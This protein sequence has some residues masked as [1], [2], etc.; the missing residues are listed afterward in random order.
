MLQRILVI[1]DDDLSREVVEIVLSGEGYEVNGASSGEVAME[2]LS[3]SG[4]L[5]DAVLMDMQ[6]PGVSGEELARR[7]RAVCGESMRLIA[8]SGS[9]S[10]EAESEE[11]DGFLLKPFSAEEFRAILERP[12]RGSDGPGGAEEPRESE[13]GGGTDV[14]D[15]QIFASF[16]A[17]MSKESLRDLYG[18]CV[19]DATRQLGAMRSA[20]AAGDD[21]EFRKSAHLIKG[22]LGMLGVR[23]LQGMCSVLEEQG[24]TDNQKATLAEFPAAIERLRRMLIARGV[25]LQPEAEDPRSVEECR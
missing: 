23:E 20:A 2:A 18:A 25:E 21:T 11:F 8:M 9:R 17:I 16:Q 10:R 7:L 1:D 13:G 5:P 3:G 22:G 24:L 12:G 6:M 15:S 14:L 4:A 19:A